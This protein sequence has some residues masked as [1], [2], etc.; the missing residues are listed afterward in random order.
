MDWAMAI[1]GPMMH[2]A[3]SMS[4]AIFFMVCIPCDRHSGPDN[5]LT[6]IQPRHCERIVWVRQSVGR[7]SIAPAFVAAGAVQCASL[8]APTAERIAP[9]TE[10]GDW[11]VRQIDSCV[12]RETDA[13]GKSTR[14]SGKNT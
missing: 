6:T 12:G 1:E 11:R 10:L 5:L 4:E 13:P 9:C 2:A 8:I 3:N 14:E 7:N